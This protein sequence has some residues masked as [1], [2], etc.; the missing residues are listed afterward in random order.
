MYVNAHFKAHP[1]TSLAFA[2]ARG[3]GLVIASDGGCPVG[4]HL[5]FR[6]IEADGNASL[7]TEPI[8]PAQ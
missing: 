5:P 2:A 4:A 3:F 1:A 6:L 7:P 8:D